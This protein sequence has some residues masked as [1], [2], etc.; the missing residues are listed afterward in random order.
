MNH[1]AVGIWERVRVRDYERGWGRQVH[2]CPTKNE[3][4]SL[5]GHSEK[6]L[7]AQRWVHRSMNITAMWCNQP[8]HLCR[9]RK[10]GN[11]SPSFA[12]HPSL[13]T[14]VSLPPFPMTSMCVHS[15]LLILQFDP[16][17]IYVLKSSA[18]LI[19]TLLTV[20]SHM[21]DDEIIS[22][23]GYSI[24]KSLSAPLFHNVEG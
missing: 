4:S 21:L 22:K 7:S 11:P 17:P 5:E 16:S 12:L 18:L 14:P 9:W 20:F 6:Q 3:W 15:C 2:P 19:D 13:H 10:A 24:L 23:L 1:L 8:K